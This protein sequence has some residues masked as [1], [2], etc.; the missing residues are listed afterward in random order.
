[1]TF[2]PSVGEGDDDSGAGHV[3]II[4]GPGLTNITADDDDFETVSNSRVAY[5]LGLQFGLDF[6]EF[7]GL[8]PE[9][10]FS[11]RGW[12]TSGEALGIDFKSDYVFSYL[13]LPLLLRIGVPLEGALAPKVLIGPHGSLFL[14]GERGGEAGGPFVNGSG[15]TDIDPSDVHPGQF[16][17]AAGVGIDFN[18]GGNGVLTTDVRFVRNFTGT[19]DVGDGEENVYHQSWY[20]MGGIIF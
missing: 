15:Q 5:S 12:E 18:L 6:N 11:R 10:L 3:G 1:V 8:A 9:L 17:V 4:G 19:F 16:G 7:F 20:V 14:D 2:G 13:D